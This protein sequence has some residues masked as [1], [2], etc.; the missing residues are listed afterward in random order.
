MRALWKNSLHVPAASKD[1][2][3]VAK[4][5]AHYRQRG[6]EFV[7][8]NHARGFAYDGRHCPLKQFLHLRESGREKE[9]RCSCLINRGAS[10]HHAIVA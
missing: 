4:R 2:A 7:G 8:T 5:I 10:P 9:S 1:H 3:T 6:V